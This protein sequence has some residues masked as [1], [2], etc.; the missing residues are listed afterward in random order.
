[1]KHSLKE[2]IDMVVEDSLDEKLRGGFD[3]NN[4]KRLKSPEER[5]AYAKEYLTLKLGEGGSRDAWAL[6]TGKVLKTI[7]PDEEMRFSIVQCQNEYAAFEKYGPEYI[8]RVFDKAPDFTWLIVEPV[9]AF[10]LI[11]YSNGVMP[12]KCGFG[13][14]ALRE[15]G[16]FVNRGTIKDNNLEILWNKCMDKDVNDR[17]IENPD[18]EVKPLAPHFNELTPMGQELLQKFLLLSSHGMIDIGRSDHW[19]W[20]A[21]GRVVCLDPGVSK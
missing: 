5:T 14:W 20:A 16:R 2:F 18:E 15:F 4:F 19:G 13:E 7:I 1:M 10:S 9:R 11:T 12:Q 21:D 8:P 3:L 17:T 6:S